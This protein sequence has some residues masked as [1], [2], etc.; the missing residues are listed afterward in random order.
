MVSNDYS[1]E[2]EPPADGMNSPP[3]DFIAQDRRS[4][5]DRAEIAQTPERLKAERGRLQACTEAMNQIVA[6]KR[7]DTE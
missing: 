7:R 4:P 6:E 1:P 2:H 3:D 5:P